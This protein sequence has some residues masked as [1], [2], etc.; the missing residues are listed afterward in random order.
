MWELAGPRVESGCAG[1]GWD[2]WR[3]AIGAAALAAELGEWTTQPGDG[4]CGR[5]CAGADLTIEL[6][7]PFWGTADVIPTDGL[8]RLPCP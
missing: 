5:L 2:G 3:N 1:R 7:C 4:R 6:A 8:P